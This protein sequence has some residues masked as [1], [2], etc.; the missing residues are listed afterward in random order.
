MSK[1]HKIKAPVV[2]PPEPVYT[3]KMTAE[4]DGV[5]ITLPPKAIDALLTF[6]REICRAM[7]VADAEIADCWTCF[8]FQMN[9][10]DPVFFF[11]GCVNDLCND[12]EKHAYTPQHLP[13]SP[14]PTEGS[15]R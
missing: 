5:V 7:Q 10:L 15:P 4:Y 11:G 1:S 9:G 13:V 2:K 6:G 12:I 8:T 14:T 3:E